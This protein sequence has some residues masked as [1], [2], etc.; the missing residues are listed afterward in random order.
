MT[1][2]A[3]MTNY[4]ALLKILHKDLD[5]AEKYYQEAA[6]LNTLC[7]SLP[8]SVLFLS[9]KGITIYISA[10]VKPLDVVALNNYA[11]FLETVRRN[12]AQAEAVYKRALELV[13]S[14]RGGL[15][16]G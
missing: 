8:L 1:S 10:E 12:P 3:L 2:Q 14:F 7:L 16:E 4:A 13:C 6:G 5:Q 9:D 15:G 11:Q